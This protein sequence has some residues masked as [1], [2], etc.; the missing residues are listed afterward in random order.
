MAKQLTEDEILQQLDPKPTSTPLPPF[1]EQGRPLPPSTTPQM[2]EDDILQQLDPKTVEVK[3]HYQPWEV[4]PEMMNH[5]VPSAA[6]FLGNVGNAFTHPLDTANSLLDTIGGIP[7]ALMPESWRQNI[8]KDN[9]RA[10]EMLNDTNA[11]VKDYVNH[12]GGAQ[13]IADTIAE[14]PIRLTT[15]AATV[16]APGAGAARSVLGA[17]RVPGGVIDGLAIAANPAR[18]MEGPAQ[19]AGHGVRAAVNALDPQANLMMRAAEGQGPNILTS[20]RSPNREIVPGSAPTAGQA[21]A[22]DLTATRWQ[23]LDKSAQKRLPTEATNIK[24]AQNAAR[25]A[26]VRTV[27]QTPADLE[28]AITAREAATRRNYAAANGVVSTADDTLFDLFER[29]SMDRVF[30]RARQIADEQGIPFE[31]RPHTPAASVASSVLG[32]DGRPMVV[33]TP[34]VL[35]QWR[36]QQLHIVKQAF[37]DMIKDPAQFGIGASEVRAIQRTRNE[38]IDWFEN[39]NPAYRT[40]RQEHAAASRPID[41]MRIGQYLEQKLQNPTMGEDT[42]TLRADSFSN[43]VQ[44]AVTKNTNIK[45]ATGE[46]RYRNLDEILTPDQMQAIQSVQDDLARAKRAEVEATAAGQYSGELGSAAEAPQAPSFLKT[47]VTILNALARG[48]TGHVNER[49]ANAVANA[50]MNPDAA[51]DLL[52]QAIEREARLN[53]ASS[54][55]HRVG[56]GIQAVNRVPAVYNALDIQRQ[57][58]EKHKTSR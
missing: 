13:Q 46:Q 30:A 51:A 22:D 36:G 32:P 17:A 25:L 19:L 7:L 35:P 6:K 21:V 8:L 44:E 29:P 10:Q 12:Y 57:E 55:A 23:A 33:T 38:F 42:P 4:L 37:D 49:V 58:R 9:P 45:R 5:V 41:Q 47:G 54:H 56:H 40:A 18:A 11:L 24:D 16:L 20:L 2:S 34:E 52:G 53:R 28:A 1:T 31:V 48:A 39:S 14:D 15:D 43:A 26:Q 3:R 27:G 50:M